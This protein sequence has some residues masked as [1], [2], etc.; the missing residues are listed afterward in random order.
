MKRPPPGGSAAADV[1]QVIKKPR[2]MVRLESYFYATLPGD[3]AALASEFKADMAFKCHLCKK[4]Y[5][6][7]VEFARHLSLHVES[8]RAAAVDLVDLCQCKYCFKVRREKNLFFIWHRA[9][10]TL[11]IF[12]S[13]RGGGCYFPFLDPPDRV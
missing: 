13:G 2:E 11:Q 9:W 1:A 7:N 3:A 12:K 10:L 8:D 5:M 4:V 6:N